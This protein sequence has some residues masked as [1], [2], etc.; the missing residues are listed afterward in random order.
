M[1]ISNSSAVPY[2]YSEPYPCHGST[3]RVL[4]P[5]PFS[6]ALK[7]TFKTK[8]TLGNVVIFPTVHDRGLGYSNRFTLCRGCTL[9]P[10]SSGYSS[11]GHLP[12]HNIIC[13]DKHPIKAFRL[14]TL[15]WESTLWS[16]YLPGTP[17]HSTSTF[18]RN[19]SA[20]SGDPLCLL[21]ARDMPL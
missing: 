10:Q 18:E 7:T 15:V 16:I 12:P 5:A 13:H 21:A 4:R 14:S 9:Y 17:W 11:C 20:A 2:K 8:T 6:S 3:L 19:S 1:T